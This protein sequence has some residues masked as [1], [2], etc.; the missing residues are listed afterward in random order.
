MERDTA[1]VFFAIIESSGSIEAPSLATRLM[2]LASTSG[3]VVI[4]TSAGS[5]LRRRKKALVAI[6][7]PQLARSMRVSGRA[8]RRMDLVGISMQTRVSTLVI[9]TTISRTELGFTVGLMVT[10]IKVSGKMA[11]AVG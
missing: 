10:I 8:I 7:G 11:S 9:T 4:L 5:T 1:R 3:R 6:Y 2:V